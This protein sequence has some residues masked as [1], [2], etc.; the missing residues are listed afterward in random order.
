MKPIADQLFDTEKNFD[1]KWYRLEQTLDAFVDK[2]LQHYTSMAEECYTLL[3]GTNHRKQYEYND[4]DCHAWRQ[5]LH[6]P[7]CALEEGRR[8]FVHTD[9]NRC[10][11]YVLQDNPLGRLEKG[12][13]DS[14]REKIEKGLYGPPVTLTMFDAYLHEYGAYKNMEPLAKLVN[15]GGSRY[16][17]VRDE[18]YIAGASDIRKRTDGAWTRLPRVR[19]ALFNIETLHCALTEED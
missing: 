18:E 7:V 10:I 8:A 1:M 2:M 11:L 16:N 4:L 12:L 3:G 17:D 15:R 6:R 19:W 9:Q 14:I 13:P 5:R